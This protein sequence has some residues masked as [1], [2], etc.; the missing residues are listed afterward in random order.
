MDITIAQPLV[1]VLE[2]DIN[3]VALK[4][5]YPQDTGHVKIYGLKVVV[6]KNV[7]LIENVRDPV[8]NHVDLVGRDPVVDHVDLVGRDPVVDHVDLVGRDPVV[9]HVDLVGRDPVVNLH[10]N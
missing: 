10:V 8:V 9:D 2:P 7:H 5:N 1:A 4:I 3:A 6:V